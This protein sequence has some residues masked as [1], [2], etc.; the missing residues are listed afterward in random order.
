MD[1]GV[2][3][4]DDDIVVMVWTHSNQMNVFVV[5]FE[6]YIDVMDALFPNLDIHQYYDYIV[7]ILNQ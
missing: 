2:D 3:H 5:L 7:L 4:D 1:R 6:T